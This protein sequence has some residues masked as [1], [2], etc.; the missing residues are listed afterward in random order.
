MD[1]SEEL[2]IFYQIESGQTRHCKGRIVG[3]NDL[4]FLEI[5]S[6]RLTLFIE[7]SRV[8]RVERWKEKA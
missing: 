4:G 1:D 8:L 7:P 2:D 3:K 6:G 5:A